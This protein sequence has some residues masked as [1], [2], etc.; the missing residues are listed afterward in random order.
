MAQARRIW[1]L[2]IEKRLRIQP[3][4]G[5][6]STPLSKT[7]YK[8][9]TKKSPV[10]YCLQQIEGAATTVSQSVAVRTGKYAS[11]RDRNCQE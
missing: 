2:G 1:K 7:T 10:G 11:D 5:D 3:P 4:A 9:D 6:E 8:I